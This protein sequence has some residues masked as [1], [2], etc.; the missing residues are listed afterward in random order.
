MTICRAI[1]KDLETLAVLF[2]EYRVFYNRE[3]DLSGA[4]TFLRQRIENKD[5]MIFVAKDQSGMMMGFVQLYPIFSSVRMKRLWL[6]NDLYV[7]P[8]YRGR[9]ISVLLIDAAKQLATDTESA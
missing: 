2:D 9:K 6:L 7:N 1:E 8:Q 3:S 4:R 5:S